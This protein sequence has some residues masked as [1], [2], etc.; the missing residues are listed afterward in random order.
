MELLKKMCPE[1]DFGVLSPDLL[2]MIPK[3]KADTQ[4]VQH[5]MRA[6]YPAVKPILPV[7][8]SWL[9]DYNWPV[10]QEL[11]PFLASIGTPLKEPV[12]A[13]LKTDD[14]IWKY[15]VLSL[16]VNTPDL[17]LATALEEELNTLCRRNLQFSA[18]LDEDQQSVNRE[19]ESLLAKLGQP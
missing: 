19:V 17:K 6:G 9:Q 4:A 1:F 14:I 5:A 2:S 10:A 18:S 13:V 8:L 15:W 11:T 12:A 7:L 16:L 3:N